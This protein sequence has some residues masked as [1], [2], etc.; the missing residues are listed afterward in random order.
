MDL[1]DLQPRRRSPLRLRGF[2]YAQPGAYFV[3]VCAHRR[4]PLFGAI[5]EGIVR[6]SLEGE[7]VAECWKAIGTH[8]ASALPDILVVM[9]NHVHGILWLQACP[10]TPDP[11]DPAG[12]RHAS[13]LRTVGRLPASGALSL[14]AI[15]GSFKSATSRRINLLRG[16]PG[17]PVWQRGFHEHVIRGEED[18]DRVRRYIEANP[19]RWADDE[20]NP[21]RRPSAARGCVR[22]RR[23]LRW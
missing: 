7:A 17:A 18:L 14:S 2:D 19:I 6:P 12:A 1:P 22:A 16:T 13:P 8:S 9:P 3:T 11:P 15:V 20:E 23:T 10:P 4:L 21:A 5:A